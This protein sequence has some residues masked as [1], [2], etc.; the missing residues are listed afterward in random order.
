MKKV[1]SAFICL[2][3]LNS[4]DDGDIVVETFDFGS[5]G[6]QKCSNNDI[7]LK[8]SGNQLMLLNISPEYFKNQETPLNT[9]RVYTISGSSEVIYRSYTGDV[10]NSSICA[11]IPPSSPAVVD[12]FNAQS[13][14]KVEITT[15]MIPTVNQTTLSTQITYSHLIKFKNVQFAN[16][17]AIISFPEYLFG[18]YT[19]ANNTL[20]FSF[21]NATPQHCS[22][23]KIFLKNAGQFLLLDLPATSF[24]SQAGTQTLN[25]D[26]TNKVIY[27][28]YGSTVN[29]TEYPTDLACSGNTPTSPIVLNEEWIADEGA[30]TIVTTEVFDPTNTTVIGYKH[31]IT[32]Q[33]IK[34]KKGSQ[35]FVHPAYTFGDYTVNN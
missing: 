31:H 26:A 21:P 3:L 30:V 5:V 18:T 22:D 7:L 10:T 4:C 11:T 14:G 13:G 20:S 17:S 15:T 33:N 1:F 25:L 34:Y 24:P 12:E 19:S 29:G 35:S 16:N 2:F 8:T 28:M 9:P 6:V 23:N 32:F 27:R